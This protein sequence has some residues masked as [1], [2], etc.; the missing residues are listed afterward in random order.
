MDFNEIFELY[1]AYRAGGTTSRGA[2]LHKLVT[3]DIPG[4]L[5][6]VCDEEFGPDSDYATK[7]STGQARVADVP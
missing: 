1:D 4:W 7:G 6:E 3:Q 5:K 2:R